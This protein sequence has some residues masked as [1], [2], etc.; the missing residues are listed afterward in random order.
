MDA[1]GITAI[2]VAAIAAIVLWALWRGPLRVV[3]P[4]GAAALRR[5]PRWPD[6]TF[7]LSGILRGAAGLCLAIALGRPTGLLPE[8]R[9]GGV[10]VDLILALDASGSMRALDATLE[11]RR[12][13]RLELARRV[14][15]DFVAK[16]RGDRIGLVVFGEKAFTQCPL[17]VDHRLVL[18]ALERVRVG[19]AGDATALGEAI[20]LATRRLSVPGAPAEGQ[21]VIVVFTDGRHNSGRIAPETAARLARSRGVRIHAVGIGGE[22][23][24]PFAQETPG[25]PLR[26]EQVDL[27][28]DTLRALAEIT[29]GGFFHARE[30]A[31][32]ADVLHAIDQLEAAPLGASPEV[33]SASLVP[34]ALA[35]AL[36]LLL[37]DTL[38][39]HGWLRRVP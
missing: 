8:N 35:A 22:G 4:D 32:L 19:L 37:A 18:K 2:G 16:R 9:A 24:V 26:F 21:R 7:T 3:V 39:A 33:R 6:P 5:H 34:L 28:Q 17:T 11:G 10:G 27:D 20:G 1:P 25:Q 14:V 30:P 15:A 12:V 38:T 13:T 36:A 31:D 23:V 29:G